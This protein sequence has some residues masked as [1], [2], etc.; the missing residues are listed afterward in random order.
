MP[1]S[2]RDLGPGCATSRPGAQLWA[3][4]RAPGEQ[5]GGS[6]SR[7]P[8]SRPAEHRPG[9]SGPEPSPDLPRPSPDLPRGWPRVKTQVTLVPEARRTLCSGGGVLSLSGSPCCCGPSTS[10]CL[11]A[12]NKEG[13]IRAHRM[14]P[15]SFGGPC[16]GCTGV[17]VP[18]PG[19]LWTRLP[20]FLILTNWELGGKNCG[21]ALGRLLV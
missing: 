2:T 16:R 20:K 3:S 6:S 18:K 17:A 11:M 19:P 5:R 10:K 7:R 13:M 12:V 8:L 1:C 4:A 14:R 9:G 21:N 15:G